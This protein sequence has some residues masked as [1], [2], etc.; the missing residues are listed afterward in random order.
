M[1]R[2]ERLE[3]LLSHAVSQRS[4]RIRVVTDVDELRLDE[5][6]VRRIVH[7]AVELDHALVESAPEHVLRGERAREVVGALDD[8][9]RSVLELVGVEEETERDLDDLF[10]DSVLVVVRG[11][12]RKALRELVDAP[13]VQTGGPLVP[14]DYRKV[15]PNLPEKLP[16]GLVKSVE[17]ARRE[18]EEYIRKSGAKRIVLVREEDDRVGEVLEEELPEVAEELGVDHEVIVVPDFT[19]LSPSDLLSG[20]TK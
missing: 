4:G 2:V 13:I 9:L 16:E 6:I 8:I 17:R 18:L 20:R 7:R 19:E 1:T 3:E 11:R 10:K 12:E 5:E 15:N 14:E